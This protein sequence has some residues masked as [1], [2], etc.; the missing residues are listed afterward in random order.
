MYL[1]L[2]FYFFALDKK[3]TS[4][5]EQEDPGFDLLNIQLGQTSFG[6]HFN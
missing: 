2:K 4:T 3:T 5:D 1:M 6:K